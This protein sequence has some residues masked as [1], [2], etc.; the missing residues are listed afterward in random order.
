[1]VSKTPAESPWSN[2]L[3]EKH[4]GLWKSIFYK[5][6]EDCQP[7]S[8]CEFNEL[9]DKVTQSKNSMMRKH[10]FSPYQHVFGC[11]LRIPQTILEEGCENVPYMSGVIHGVESYQRSQQIRQ[12]ARKALVA[13]DDEDRLR[14]ATLHRTREIQR[15]FEVGDFVFFWR[16]GQDQKGSWRG[17]ARVI[18]FFEKK[19]SLDR[20]WQQGSSLCSRADSTAYG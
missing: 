4:G 11:D 19:Q 15:D 20:I 12:A 14:A 17:P 8:R 9:F 16:K 3:C 2:G 6:A 7:R 13:Q 1:M 5:A 18:G 10:G